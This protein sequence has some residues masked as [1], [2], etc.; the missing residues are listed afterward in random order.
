MADSLLLSTMLVDKS[1]DIVDPDSRSKVTERMAVLL[2][3]PIAG[4]DLHFVMFPRVLHRCGK[5]LA[6]RQVE[7]V[8]GLKK[9]NWRMCLDR[10]H[11]KEHLSQV[12]KAIYGDSEP[13]KKWI[14]RR[15]DELDE[16]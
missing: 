7:I 6:R 5:N 9:E 11:A 15:Y 13:G 1:E 3:V 16:G 8:L 12:G 14:Q 4:I 2:G 10:F